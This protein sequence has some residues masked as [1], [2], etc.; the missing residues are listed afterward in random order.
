MTAAVKFSGNG[1]IDRKI[2][3]ERGMMLEEC[4]VLLWSYVIGRNLRTSPNL[5]ELNGPHIVKR[6]ETSLNNQTQQRLSFPLPQNNGII[7]GNSSRY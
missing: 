6:G 2:I 5:H 1:I 3:H 4:V 7:N